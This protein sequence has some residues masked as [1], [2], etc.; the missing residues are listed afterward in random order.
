MI[1]SIFSECFSARN[2]KSLLF[3][4]VIKKYWGRKPLQDWRRSTALD[5]W[6]SD[7][8]DDQKL[9]SVTHYRSLLCVC[10]FRLIRAQRRTWR[11]APITP[12]APSSTRGETQHNTTQ[13]N[14]TQHNTTQHNTTA[15]CSH[16]FTA[17][18]TDAF[19]IICCNKIIITIFICIN[20]FS[21]NNWTAA[22][23]QK[24]KQNNTK[25]KTNKPKAARAKTKEHKSWDVKR[26]ED[27]T[28]N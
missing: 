6:P 9:W 27:Q 1:L 11:S 21:N 28:F 5:W 14:T 20:L 4:L 2:S 22:T 25:Q 26:R 15:A 23:K 19:R 3:L 16:F 13:H 18:I 7:A 10:V 17:D 8:I 12:E 24:C